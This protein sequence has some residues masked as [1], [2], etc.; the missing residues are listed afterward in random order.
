MDPLSSASAR[1]TLLLQVSG[2]DRPGVTAALFEGLSRFVVEVLD[3]EQSV[4]RGSLL[5]SV[6]L[7]APTNTDELARAAAEIGDSL[8]MRVEVS[9]GLGDN[10]RRPDGRAHVTMLGRQLSPRA[11]AAISGR[12]ADTGANI[13][14]IVRVARYPVTAI[15]LNIS[16]AD[17][18]RLR[19][20]LAAEAAR[21]RVDVAVQAAGLLRHGRRLLVM[22]VDST[23]VQG[24]VIDLLAREAGVHDE[25]AALTAQ[26]MRGELDFTASLRARVALLVGLPES[27]FARVHEALPLTPGAR[28]LV[29]TLSRLGYRFALV[30]GGFSAVTDRIAAELGIEHTASNVLEVADG[31]LTGRLVGPVIDA[32]GKATALQRI[33]DE[34]G[35]DQRRTIAVG[36]GAND[37]EMLAAAG[38]GI[39]FNGKPVLR[40][41]ADTA[42]SVPYLDAVMYLLGIHRDDIED[43]D[44]IE[45]IRTP[46]PAV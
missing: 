5:L 7:T 29:R 33:A 8:G 20:L 32:A 38:L 18:A 11:V 4:V 24:E 2:P 36:D 30:S 15:E 16:G 6:L 28:T 10:E 3:I 42:M 13:D 45:G 23:L 17:V 19:G 21:Q 25:V 22:D 44:L 43:E 41:R 26:A 12:I 39:A 14:R 35:I 31:R 9:R 37:V 1:H 40:E 46:R 34:L 27:V